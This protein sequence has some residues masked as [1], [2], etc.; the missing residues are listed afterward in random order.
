M[1]VN[2]LLLNRFQRRPKPAVEALDEGILRRFAR[3]DQLEL[4][5]V[6]VGPLVQCLA[7]KFWPLICPDRLEITPEAGCLIEHSGHVMSRYSEINGEIDGLLAE[8]IDD[9]QHLDPVAIGQCV[10]DKVHRPDLIR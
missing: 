6:L 10:T 4:H 5:A 8:V 3:L 9:G 7:G 1:Q 2:L